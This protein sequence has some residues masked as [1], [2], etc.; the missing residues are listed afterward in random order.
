MGTN[1]AYRYQIVGAPDRPAAFVS[2]QGAARFCN[3]LENGQGRGSILTGAYDF[4]TNPSGWP[5]GSILKNPNANFRLP[6]ANEWFKAAY[7]DPTKA[8][9]NKYWRYATRSDTLPGNDSFAGANQANFKAGGLYF[10]TRSVTLDPSLNYL[11]DV[12][13]FRNSPSYYGTFDQNGNLNEWIDVLAVGKSDNR[14]RW[15]GAWTDLTDERMK[16]SDF[17]PASDNGLGSYG[18]GE[19]IGFRILCTTPP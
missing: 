9:T 16:S 15:G 13:A 19:H 5:S 4:S 3:W 11:T 2:W 7:H 18:Q 12:G 10:L 14:M 17:L 1:G 8:G 6:N